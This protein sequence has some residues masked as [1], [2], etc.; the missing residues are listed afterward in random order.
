MANLSPNIIIII[1]KYNYI[2]ICKQPKIIIIC[3]QPKNTNQMTDWWS[4]LKKYDPNMLS[5]RNSLQIQ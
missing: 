2:I 4:E 3:K 1:C 5:T